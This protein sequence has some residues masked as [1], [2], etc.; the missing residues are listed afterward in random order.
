MAPRGPVGLGP[1][2]LG[3]FN[4]ALSDHADNHISSLST[5][6]CI[7]SWQPRLF[8]VLASAGGC[9]L[10]DTSSVGLRTLVRPSGQI[11]Q[12]MRPTFAVPPA[13]GPGTTGGADS[14]PTSRA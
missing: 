1:A 6:R 7:R 2:T 5:L 10:L 8:R 14:C 4:R 9:H 11:A 12:K 3:G 13:P